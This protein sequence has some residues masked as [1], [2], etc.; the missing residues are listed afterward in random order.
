LANHIFKNAKALVFSGLFFKS[1]DADRWLSKGLCLLARELDE[2]ILADGGHFERSPMY[3][4]MILEDCLDLL[5]V[6]HARNEWRLKNF[7]E[8]LRT[9]TRKMV[10]F[11]IE[12][13]HPDGEIAL[14]NDSAFGIEAQ[15]SDFQLLV[16]LS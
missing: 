15:P 8:R 14:F 2:Q 9:T 13:T 6:F 12:L 5:N 11:L 1:H 7:S 16:I 10:R 3:H 4:S